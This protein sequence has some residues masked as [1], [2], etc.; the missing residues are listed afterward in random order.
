MLTS[1]NIFLRYFIT[2]KH[3]LFHSTSMMS[4]EIKCSSDNYSG[5]EWIVFVYRIYGLSY[6]GYKIKFKWFKA[7]I[8]LW[9]L[10]VLSIYV[11][12]IAFVFTGYLSIPEKENKNKFSLVYVLYYSAYISHVFEICFINLIIMFKGNK[13]LESIQMKIVLEYRIDDRLFGSV[14]IVT[15]ISITY[16]FT[17]IWLSSS[18]TQFTSF[19]LFIAI[20]ISPFDVFIPLSV[21]GLIIYKIK[22]ISL[23]IR[24]LKENFKNYN[25][26]E[27][28]LILIKLKQN[29]NELSKSF[30]PVLL[31]IIINSTLIIISSICMITINLESLSTI[32]KINYFT[33]L[34]LHSIFILC[35]CYSCG[36]I[37]NIIASF[38][39]IIEINVSKDL[40]SE[41]FSNDWKKM[42]IKQDLIL[43]SNIS[44]EI[45]L[46]ASTLFDMYS[47]TVLSIISVIISY[48]VI[49]IQTTV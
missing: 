24:Y 47:S 21:I 29:I 6:N 3:S 40:C 46:N 44:K 32:T 1:F 48:T 15:Q 17:I 8:Y 36:I 35:L 10:L 12:S 41:C 9:N 30:S 4:N 20:L 39:H 25:L 22:I 37:P 5:F 7:L 19:Q 23:Q 28:Y 49:L 26:N 14:I 18:Y 2:F 11:L 31:A 16:I 33:C 27:L 34:L 43:I 45:V 13:I 42:C 38:V